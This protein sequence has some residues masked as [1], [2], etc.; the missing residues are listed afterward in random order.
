MCNLFDDPNE[1]PRRQWAKG[2]YGFGNSPGIN[3]LQKVDYGKEL[4]RSMINDLENG[5][6]EMNKEILINRSLG[7]L[8]DRTKNFPDAQLS[9]QIPG[10]SDEILSC[11]T[12]IFVEFPRQYRYG[13]RCHTIFLVDN[14]NNATYFERRR[15]ENAGEKVE[16]KDKL[17][18][19]IIE[20]S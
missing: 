18:E 13:T 7:I 2:I 17:Y 1:Q 4:L 3:P 20:E 6:M 12:S 5:T 9:R 11:R 8:T 19:F 14:E 16:W 15:V 10:T